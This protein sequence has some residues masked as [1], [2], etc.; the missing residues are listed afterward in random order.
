MTPVPLYGVFLKEPTSLLVVL[1]LI[2]SALVPF[3]QE[4]AN[5]LPVPL[6]KEERTVINPRNTITLKRK[7]EP[8]NL[9]AA[10]L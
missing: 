8:S 9:L 2:S 6:V 4:D 3:D 5:K 1:R 7:K 10:H